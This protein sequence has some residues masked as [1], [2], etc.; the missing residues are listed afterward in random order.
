MKKCLGGWAWMIWVLALLG[1]GQVFAGE[2][3]CQVQL[4]WGTDDTKPPKEEIKPLEPAVR[5]RLRQLRWKSYFVVK[6]EQ[7]AVGAKER[8]KV[9]LS[10]RCA[11]DLK[12]VGNG[13]IEVRMHALKPGAEPKQIASRTIS[14]KELNEGKLLI[15][16]GDSADRWDDAWLVIVGPAKAPVA[17]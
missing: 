3:K 12:D 15:Y 2:I 8:T 1:A 16:A 11:V 4:V 10:D 14:V 6:T 9:V 5:E 7:A 13:Q 17:K